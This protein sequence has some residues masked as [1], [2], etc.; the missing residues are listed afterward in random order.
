MAPVTWWGLSLR[1]AAKPVK[2]DFS[3]KQDKR[4]IE[5]WAKRCPGGIDADEAKKYTG[6][7]PRFVKEFV[8]R[9]L[10]LVGIPIG[11][12][13]KLVM[14]CCYELSNLVCAKF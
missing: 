11:K 1:G 10:D 14:S 13:C 6:F 8:E 5:L 2:R 3:P 9:C 7:L 12:V 4:V